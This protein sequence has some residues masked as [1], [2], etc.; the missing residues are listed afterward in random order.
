MAELQS[1]QRKNK[2]AVTQSVFSVTFSVLLNSCDILCVTSIDITALEKCKTPA[3]R[4]YSPVDSYMRVAYGY[5]ERFLYVFDGIYVFECCFFL[6]C[7]SK[8]FVINI[9]VKVLHFPLT[10]YNTIISMWVCVLY[11]FFVQFLFVCD[12][13]EV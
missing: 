12:V 8:T 7:F 9:Q 3:V 1:A 11:A 5:R 4:L 2:G 10:V 6:C 13:W